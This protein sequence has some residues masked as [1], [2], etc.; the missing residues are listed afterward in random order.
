MMG[1]AR[2]CPIPANEFE[3]RSRQLKKSFAAAGGGEGKHFP[4]VDP[5]VATT[6]NYAD[7]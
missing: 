2:I 5:Y 4:S 3:C 7:N 1:D 6:S